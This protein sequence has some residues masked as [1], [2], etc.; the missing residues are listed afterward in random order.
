MVRAVCFQ[1]NAREMCTGVSLLFVPLLGVPFACL[2]A[3]VAV[4]E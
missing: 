3:V 2:F 1:V 4:S